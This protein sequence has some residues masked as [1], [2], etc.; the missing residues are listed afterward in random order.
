M[1]ERTQSS[2]EPGRADEKPWTADAWSARCHQ[3]RTQFS[4]ECTAH[5]WSA[6]CLKAR[7]AWQR[8][9][10]TGSPAG[11]DEMGVRSEQ[12]DTRASQFESAMQKGPAKLSAKDI[13]RVFDDE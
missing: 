12:N 3:E 7:T 13:A 10:L 1:G 4:S 6:R 5:A 9:L 8:E 2:S 11:A